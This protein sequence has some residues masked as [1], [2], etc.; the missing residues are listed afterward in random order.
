MRDARLGIRV[1]LVVAA[2]SGILSSPAWAQLPGSLIVT[3]TSPGSGSTVSG[4]IPVNASVTLIGGLTVRGVQFKLDGVNLGAEDTVAPHSV[5][6]AT[7]AASNGSHTLTAVARDALGLLWTSNPVTVT[8]A[9]NVTRLE[10]TVSAV[11]YTGTWQ[12]GNTERAWSGGT[13]AVSS[14]ASARATLSFTGT[15]VSWIGY[16]GPGAG[17]ARILLDGTPVAS[18]DA[19]AASEEVSAVLFTAGALTAAAH[20]LAIEVTGDRNPGATGSAVAVDAFEVRSSGADAAQTFA[21]GD[22][23][24]SLETGPLQWWRPDGKLNRVLGGIVP[25]TGEGVAFDAPGNLYVTR[26]CID[27]SCTT[28]GNTVEKFD[29]HGRPQGPFGGGYDCSPHAIVFDGQGTAYVGQAGCTGAIVK[30]VPGEPPTTL[31]AAP[32]AQGTFW[33]DLAADACTLL[34]TSWGPNVKRYDGCADV[35]RP[36]FN[37]APLPGGETQDLR[38]LPDGGLLVSSGDVIA[39]L[40]AT[41]ALVQTYAVPG[42]VFWA[43]LA[44]VGDGT[45]WAGSYASSTVHRFDI[46]TGNVLSSFHAGTPP[47]TVVGVAV[48]R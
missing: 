16:R 41:G 4:T 11:A 27:P 40:D 48:M 43:G 39:R 12:Q 30:L 10:E 26:W 5:A 20:T 15:A 9:N 45:F 24:V 34:Y 7:S 8:V 22:V 21:P 23:V 46:A 1:A 14:A 47:H 35:Q 42:A 28:T 44:L 18:V 36:D 2:G 13:A 38:V 25:G 31:A 17:V 19:F 29:V 37:V 32:E 6:W 33:V 3:V